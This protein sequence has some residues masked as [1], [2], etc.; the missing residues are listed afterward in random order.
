MKRRRLPC[1]ACGAGCTIP[2]EGMLVEGLVLH[3][4]CATKVAIAIIR[5][6]RRELGLFKRP[7][8]KS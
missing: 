5:A 4:W 7:K 3:A 8:V 1:A 6:L 2:D